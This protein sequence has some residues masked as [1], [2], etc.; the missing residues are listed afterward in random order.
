MKN[1]WEEVK[2][3]TEGVDVDLDK[4][5]SEQCPMIIWLDDI[6]DPVKYGYP[7]AIW[8]KTAQDFSQ[9][10][11]SAIDQRIFI[12]EIHFDNDLGE[13][14]HGEGYDC[15]LAVENLLHNG[16]LES[17][18]KIYVHSSNPSAVHKFMLAAR[19]LKYHFGIDIIRN[20]Y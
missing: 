11:L 1:F 10:L 9:Y 16:E 5:L 15:F 13:E 7:E 2:S 12:D 14:S 6:R 20:Q 18:R 3:L 4:T 17:L 19:S 8:I